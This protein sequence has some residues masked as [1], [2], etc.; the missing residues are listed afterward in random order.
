[1]NGPYKYVEKKGLDDDREIGLPI[2]FRKAFAL[3]L[4]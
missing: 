2:L 4:Q 3:S 1:M